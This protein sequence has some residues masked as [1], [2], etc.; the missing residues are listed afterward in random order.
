MK[1]ETW[2]RVRLIL[3]DALELPLGE[4]AA[5]ARH[6]SAGDEE[7]LESIT[8]LLSSAEPCPDFLGA[9]RMQRPAAPVDLEGVQQVG[10]YRVLYQLGSGGMGAVF[11]AE[12]ASLGRRVALKLLPAA[13]A[14]DSAQARFRAEVQMLAR[15]RHP[16]I[17]QI[18]EAG[19]ANVA[20][21]EVPWFAMEL[22]EGSLDLLTWAD[23]SGASLTERLRLFGQL[24]EAVEHGHG[25]GVLHRD[26]K[27]SN[28]LVDG[29][30]RVRLIDFGIARALEGGPDD[31]GDAGDALAHTRTGWLIGTPQCMAPE[32]LS[33]DERDLD[34]RC[35]VYALGALLF[36]LACG[37]PPHDFTGQSLAAITRILRDDEPARPRSL[38]AELP[39][40]LEWV[41][42]K[43]LEKDR[44]LRYP[45]VAA[46]G[47]DLRR[48][49]ADE[50]VSAGP[51]SARYRLVK[52][53][54]RNRVLVAGSAAVLAGLTL[55]V[56]GLGVGLLRARTAETEARAAGV[57]ALR[58]VEKQALVLEL[59]RGI[60]GGLE[61]TVEGRDVRVLDLLDVA[62]ADFDARAVPDPEVEYAFRALLGDVYHELDRF[63]AARVQLERAVALFEQVSRE[64]TGA[65]ARVRTELLLA[66]AEL[67]A[68]APE[69]GRARLADLIVRTDELDV[70]ELRLAARRML[71]A[72]LLD[73]GHHDEAAERA[74]DL[75]TLAGS[76]EDAAVELTALGYLARAHA[77]A[78][79]HETAIEYCE[80]V[81]VRREALGEDS[82]QVG[83]A[84]I[85]LAVA[86][87]R[88][89]ERQ[90]AE[91]LS[92]RATEL[93]ARQLGPAHNQTLA[94][95]MN[96][97][98]LV[99]GRGDYAGAAELYGELV[100]AYELRV[101]A[102]TLATA[103]A[104]HNLG[105][106]H[107]MQ[108]QFHTAEPF[109]RQA[110]ELGAE[111]L[112]PG[113]LNLA[114][115]ELQLGVTLGWLD[116]RFEEAELLMLGAFE[117]IEASLP[118]D[119]RTVLRAIDK[120]GI[121]YNIN[122]EEA[123]AHRWWD[124]LPPERDPRRR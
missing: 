15:L 120:L 79:R 52:F 36:E 49:R 8:R 91:E 116:G 109:L 123:E 34:V 96:L 93:F 94:A 108:K 89:G 90:R 22:V 48:L 57:Q 3:E 53:A 9:P 97:A 44:R 103:T 25:R 76:L 35:D 65:E 28:V 107:H 55:A 78:G 29:D 73:A 43:A 69:S 104:L 31:R 7:L 41:I 45:T 16:R 20:G 71:V 118:A 106:C 113:D 10:D 70:P 102:P 117:R 30:G 110:L 37:Q 68:G 92:L 98:A 4:Q 5:F 38:V 74:A 119:H 121:L 88:A 33:E 66:S 2:I 112:E 32:Q 19:S 24:C 111:L 84:L 18:F 39:A 87:T 12:H 99:H 80:E 61:N 63:D 51:P 122:G 85:D 114:Q 54:R 47:E 100:L 124:R 42:L 72:Y 6:A 75:Y 82:V 58:E 21:T 86:L 67:R 50:P 40:D 46:L 105:L 14:S 26:L 56:V 64:S 1:P 115:F 60:F 83:Q 95:R 59:V 11:A 27:P 13:Y 17:A 81:L 62:A 77:A 23:E 101:E